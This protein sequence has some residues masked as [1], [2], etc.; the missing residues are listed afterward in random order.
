MNR[1]FDFVERTTKA[2]REFA[3]K[4]VSPWSPKATAP[5]KAPA[6]KAAAKRSTK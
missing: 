3:T 2:N 1:Y 6:K 4:L 5:K